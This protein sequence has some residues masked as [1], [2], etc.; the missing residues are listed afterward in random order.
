MSTPE[1]T[2]CIC[3]FQ[4]NAD[5][6][7]ARRCL[8]QRSATALFRYLVDEAVAFRVTPVHWSVYAIDL[9]AKRDKVRHDRVV[10]NIKAEYQE[11]TGS[12]ILPGTI[13]TGALN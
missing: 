9:I 8:G 2:H 5:I 7:D 11:R 12:P 6:H 4:G 10:E 3:G 1:I 13:P